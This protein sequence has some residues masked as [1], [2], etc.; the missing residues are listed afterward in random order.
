[1]ASFEIA[2]A[3]LEP[4]CICGQPS[5]SEPF[6]PVPPNSSEFAIRQSRF[7][8]FAICWFRRWGFADYIPNNGYERALLCWRLE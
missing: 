3:A 1:M 4:P 2:R 7:N 5:V 8:E 6:L